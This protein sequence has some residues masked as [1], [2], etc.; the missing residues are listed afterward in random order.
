MYWS[1]YSLTLINVKLLTW[2]S[3]NHCIYFEH[4]KIFWKTAFKIFFL[5]LFYRNAWYFD[6]FSSLF[7]VNFIYMGFFFLVLCKWRLIFKL[8]SWECFTS[9]FENDHLSAVVKDNVIH[10]KQLQFGQG[11]ECVGPLVFKWR[12]LLL[13]IELLLLAG[14]RSVFISFGNPKA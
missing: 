5:S 13:I 2:S 7:D 6:S 12:N 1:V 9:S 8:F 11:L 3:R 14:F 4:L 10:R